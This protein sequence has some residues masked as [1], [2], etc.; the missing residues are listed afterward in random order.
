MGWDAL[1]RR[2]LGLCL[3]A[4]A[5][6]IAAPAEAQLSVSSGECTITAAGGTGAKTC[7][8]GNAS[9]PVLVIWY[10]NDVAAGSTSGVDGFYM[11]GA[12]ASSTEECAIASHSDNA[13]TS[14][15]TSATFTAASIARVINPDS[16]DALADFT[17]FDATNINFN[18]SDAPSA[19]F[20][21]Q[22][23]TFAGT[24]LNVDVGID[25]VSTGTGA[26]SFTSASF[27][28]S[29]IIAARGRSVNAPNDAAGAG[30]RYAIGAATSS[31]SRWSMNS[32]SADGSAAGSTGGLWDDDVL[33]NIVTTAG[34][35]SGAFDFTQFNSDGYTIN[36]TV[37]NG[38]DTGIC[39]II[40]GGTNF[41]AA[42]GTG[43]SVTTTPATQMVSGLGHTP[44]AAL[45][46]LVSATTE[47]TPTNEWTSSIG[48]VAGIAAQRV[49]A[50]N[51]LHA[52]DPTDNFKSTSTGKAIRA[53][54][55]GTDT[56]LAEADIDSFSSDQMVVDWSTV[57]AK[58][59]RY[60][61]ITMENS[62]PAGSGQPPSSL[63]LL[64]VGAP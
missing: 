59:R 50:L 10:S 60:A 34:V 49:A 61:F 44:E 1:M 39:R 31:S 45:F 42:V 17:S 25:T 28:G 57:D 23:I 38:G 5:L 32:Y 12:S 3:V 7:A 30:A 40:M 15:T 51:D 52:A 27:Q 43:A 46:F 6:L 8:H 4:L 55:A 2:F 16:V 41:S 36:K 47:D 11:F 21:V 22:F 18:V 56:T 35:V 37:S 58:E 14:N 20:T 62:A 48:S 64:G 24:G 29:L 63:L 9:T 19:D 13:A 33:L 53:V 54:Q 26:Q